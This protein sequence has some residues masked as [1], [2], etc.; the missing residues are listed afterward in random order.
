MLLLCKSGAD[1]SND[2]DYDN[3]RDDDDWCQ[4]D[5]EGISPNIPISSLVGVLPLKH[6]QRSLVF[7]GVGASAFVK[8]PRD[9]I[10]EVPLVLRARGRRPW[11]ALNWQCFSPSWRLRAVL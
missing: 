4:D 9:L 5:N 6:S 10:G 1:D 8:V 11:R 7:D 3:N 2:D